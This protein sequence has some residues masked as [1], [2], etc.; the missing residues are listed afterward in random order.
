MRLTLILGSLLFL[1]ACGMKVPYTE[2]IK[3]QYN[4]SE[5][6]MRKVQFYTS[7]TIIL[8]RKNSQENQGT[9]VSGALVTN[10]NSVENRVIIPASTR[11]II[12]KQEANGDIY[13]RF[14]QGDNKILRFAQRKGQSNGRYY[15]YAAIW[16][17]KK[18][19]EI[20]YGNLTYYATADSGS[21]YLLVVTK[22]LRKVK[23]KDRIVK[24][25]KV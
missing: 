24:G 2:E 1:S 10:E 13:V 9:S 3:T 6:G 25:L 22:K 20:N 12:E 16:D 21:A 23:R 18:G 11:C 14:E 19:G 17:P 7:T 15:L 4:L 8:Q 5:E